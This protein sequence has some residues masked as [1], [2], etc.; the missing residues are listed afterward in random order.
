M[1]LERRCSGSD[2]GELDRHLHWKVVMSTFSAFLLNRFRASCID[3]ILHVV[4]QNGLTLHDL[5]RPLRL[6]IKHV[7]KRQALR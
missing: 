1:E 3:R 6:G 2:E 7:P 4:H 5:S